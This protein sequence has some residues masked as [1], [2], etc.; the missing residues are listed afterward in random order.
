MAFVM[1][2]NFSDA[3]QQATSKKAASSPGVCL[4]KQYSGP[5]ACC[6]LRGLTANR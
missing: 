6:T 2:E 1:A 3:V 4:P 5:A